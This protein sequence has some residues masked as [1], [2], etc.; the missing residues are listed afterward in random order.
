[1]QTKFASFL[2]IYSMEGV[3]YPYLSLAQLISTSIAGLG[4]IKE[5]RHK[6]SPIHGYHNVLTNARLRVT[7]WEQVVGGP[8]LSYMNA[9]AVHQ[10]TH[11]L[12]YSHHCLVSP[13]AWICVVEVWWASIGQHCLFHS[14]KLWQ[15]E[16]DSGTILRNMSQLKTSSR[17]MT[18]IW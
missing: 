8:F 18:L 2:Y 16:N 12:W 10:W 5:E 3:G 13:P 4:G 14:G 11:R 1:V 9:Q 7:C 15:W 6:A 17:C